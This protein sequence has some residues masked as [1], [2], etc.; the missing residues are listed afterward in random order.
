MVLFVAV[1]AIRWS[2]LPPV[3]GFADPLL[4]KVTSTWDVKAIEGDIHPQVKQ[5][6]PMQQWTEMFKVFQERLG[7]AK[8]LEPASREKI[9]VNLDGSASA[10]CKAQATFASAK[11]PATLTLSCTY[12]TGRWWVTGFNLFI[13]E[14]KSKGQATP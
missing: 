6:I 7:P 9:Q 2:M 12:A 11:N 3:L 4:A 8:T 13:P 1:L 10:V 5:Q 14:D